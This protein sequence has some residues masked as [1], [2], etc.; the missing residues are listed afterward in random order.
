MIKVICRCSHERIK[1]AGFTKKKF[2]D[3]HTSRLGR[4]VREVYIIFPARM[5][6]YYIGSYI[7]YLGH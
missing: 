5:N 4:T 7:D 2:S 3:T 6:I 1:M